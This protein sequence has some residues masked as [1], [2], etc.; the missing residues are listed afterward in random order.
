MMDEGFGT[1]GLHFVSFTIKYTSNGILCMK[2][3]LILRKNSYRNLQFT[4]LGVHH[5]NNNN[6]TKN[7]TVPKTSRYN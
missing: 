4:H 3:Y 7:N 6:N 2:M 1:A 5:S